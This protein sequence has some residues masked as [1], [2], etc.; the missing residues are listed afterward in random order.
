MEIDCPRKIVRFPDGTPEDIEDLYYQLRIEF[1]KLEHL[2]DTIP[3]Y[4]LSPQIYRVSEGWTV[5]IGDRKYLSRDLIIKGC[6]ETQITPIS[7]L[8]CG[9]REIYWR[10]PMDP[11]ETTHT[12]GIRY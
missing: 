12:N 10:I 9:E 3:I 6:M 4:I 8:A 11:E 2:D 7:E 1:M 5:I